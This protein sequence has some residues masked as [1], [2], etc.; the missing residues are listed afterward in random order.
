[1][2]NELVSEHTAGVIT[3]EGEGRT[4]WTRKHLD[5]LIQML[6]DILHH[7]CRVNKCRGGKS[8]CVTDVDTTTKC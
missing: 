4:K 1:M 8:L 6:T 5:A 3:T 2:A 7:S